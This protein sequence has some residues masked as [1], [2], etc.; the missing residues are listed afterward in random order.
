ML[1]TAVELVVGVVAVATA[2]LLLLK[3]WDD[4]SGH[5]RVRRRPRQE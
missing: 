5:A 2:G 4:Q 1:V 3:A